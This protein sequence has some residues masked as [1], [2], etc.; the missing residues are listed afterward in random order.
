M[1]EP[2]RPAGAGGIVADGIERAE[3]AAGSGRDRTDTTP[4]PGTGPAGGQAPGPVAGPPAGLPSDPPTDLESILDEIDQV[5]DPVTE[6]VAM[7]PAMGIAVAGGP[8]ITLSEEDRG[9]EP[10]RSSDSIKSGLSQAGP[11]AVAGLV[12]NGTAALVV[13]VVARLV[14]PRAYGTIAVLLGLFFILSMPGSAVLVGVV[15]RVTALNDAGRPWMVRKWV[16][17][18]HR[19]ALVGLAVELVVVLII[20]GWIARQLSLPNNDGIVLILMAAGV[21]ILLCVDR[22]LLQAHRSY[23]SLA[24]NLLLEGVVRTC[25]VLV[26][27]VG[28]MGVT[29]YAVG[30]FASEVAAT[31]HAHWLA[32]KAWS[33]TEAAT[34]PRTDTSDT[35]D[36]AMADRTNPGRAVHEPAVVDRAVVQPGVAQPAVVDPAPMPGPSGPGANPGARAGTTRPQPDSI[37]VRRRLVADV[38][39]AFVG[40]ALLGLLQNVD[41]ILLGRLNQHHVGSY[42]AISVA[43]KALVFG[44][45]ALG[46]YLLPEATIRWNEGGH[47]IRQLGVTLIFLAVPAAVLLAISVLVPKQFLTLVFGAKLSSAAPAFATLVAAMMFLSLSVLIT[48]YLFGTGSRWIVFL[49]AGGSALAAGLVYTANGRALTTARAD[50]AA[51]AVLALSMV[52]AFLAIHHRHDRHRWQFR[53]TRAPRVG[54][55]P[56]GQQET[57]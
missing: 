26:L 57:R 38:S 9:A 44:A 23:R 1:E 36:A 4:G 32:T 52:I 53:V 37:L 34:S 7:A 2:D 50:L 14:S 12:V 24:G 39:A 47:A 51:Q 30:I 29:G 42:A 16:G 11:V 20:Q 41:V 17:R 48:N 15:R 31:V 6:A 3:R 43:S 46:A 19:I 22:G 21:W 27:V 10:D 54:A 18:V 28:H 33:A 25:V 13:V 40:L 55:E 35:S 5:V 8:M 45:L 49:L 56:S